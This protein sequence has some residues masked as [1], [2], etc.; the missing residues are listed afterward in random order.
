MSR[1]IKNGVRVTAALTSIA[2]LLVGCGPQGGQ[3]SADGYPDKNI[4][5]VVG[6]AAGDI[7]SFPLNRILLQNRSVLG[8]DFG[9]R[10]MGSDPAL[11]TRTLE[12][13]YAGMAD[14]SFHPPAPTVLPL[15]QAVDGLVAL[16]ERK[17]TG[18]VV[19]A[20]GG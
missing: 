20:V 4:E 8:V 18:K 13:T 1:G 19:V 16:R 5:M 6:F 12:A 10:A 15:E 14:G 2:A 9:A 11:A 7:P 3:Q 17:V